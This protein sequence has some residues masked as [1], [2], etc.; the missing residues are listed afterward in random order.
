MTLHVL[1]LTPLGRGGAGGIDRLMDTLRADADRLRPG[2]AVRFATTRGRSIAL[3]PGRMAAAMVGMVAARAA[4]RLDLAHINLSSNASTHR[5]AMLARLCRGLGV[6]YVLHL[7]GADF[8]AYWRQ[9]GSARR[10]RID[11]MFRGAA[12]L[13][14]LGERWRRLVAERLPD[15]AD[16][17]RIVP[18]AAPIPPGRPGGPPPAVGEPVVRILF[19]GQLGDRKG[20][21]DLV[22]ALA[23]M[24]PGT[25]WRATLAGDGAV[26]QTR[27]DVAA[28][29]L[30]DKVEVPGWVGPAAVQALL[31]AAD[32]LVLPSLAENLPM[33][34]IEGMAAGLAVIATPVGAICDIVRDGETGLLSP[35]RDPPS[36]AAALQRVID[37]G[38]LRRRLGEGARAFHRAHLDTPRFTQALASA[39]RNAAARGAEPPSAEP[40]PPPRAP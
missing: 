40:P 38:P 32:I 9:D 28:A 18:N 10:R 19:L 15:V 25:P 37:D 20:S 23:M 33:S 13:I 1:V 34:V 21:P 12:G 6:P 8:D 30:S 24:Q 7:H 39:W 22:R 26:A 17:I 4:G 29:G 11:R 36:L 27:L 14:V 31:A 3:S 35:P 16:R 5:K 2:I